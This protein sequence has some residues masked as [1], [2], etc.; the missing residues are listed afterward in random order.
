MNI[1]RLAEEY[2]KQQDFIAASEKRK[3]ELKQ[4]LKHAVEQGGDLD[5]KGHR[6]LPGQ[7]YLLKL[8]RRKGSPT[9]AEDKA[10]EWA[11]QKGILD[12]L[13]TTV[14]PQPY[15]F[16]DRDKL[17]EWALKHPEDAATIKAFH[18]EAEPTYAFAKP[19]KKENYDY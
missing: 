17:A 3:E 7:D 15:S 2:L 11:A 12:D 10:K 19:Q 16:F 1:D 8:E 6:W 5:E 14:T 9:F 13:T 4:L 18:G